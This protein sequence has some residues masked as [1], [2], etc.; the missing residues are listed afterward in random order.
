MSTLWRGGWGGHV[1]TDVSCKTPSKSPRAEASAVRVG[2]EGDT[3]FRKG[4]GGSTGLPRPKMR[5]I[6]GN[7]AI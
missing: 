4:G 1:W 5:I 3:P 7:G 2:A 6:D